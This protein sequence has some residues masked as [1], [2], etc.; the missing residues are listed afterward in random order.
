[1]TLKRVTLKPENHV[2]KDLI[3][4]QHKNEVFITISEFEDDIN[5]QRE[6]GLTYYELKTLIM[7]LED[8]NFCMEHEL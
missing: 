5:S 6:V 3:I 4:R 2:S 1:M 7:I 8:L